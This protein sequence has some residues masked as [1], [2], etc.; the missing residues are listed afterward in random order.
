MDE[1]IRVNRAS[2]HRLLPAR[3]QPGAEANI[4]YIPPPVTAAP[5]YGCGMKPALRRF[6]RLLPIALLP[7]AA[8]ACST[9]SDYPSLAVRDVER[10][11]GTAK[12]AADD[13]SA[14]LPVLPPASAGLVSRLQGLV[15]VA[16]AADRQFQAE[17]PS[18]ERAAAAAGSLGSDSWSSASVALARLEASRSQAMIALAD[19]DTLYADAR[20]AAP[21]EPSPSAQAIGD[22]RAQV[23]GWVEAQ[24]AVIERLSARVK[25]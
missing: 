21:L 14:P 20:D 17:R 23:S 3:H 13:A 1:A 19:L 15:A 25:G 4:P 8:G 22:A 6:A 9:A 24:D 18:A 10:V 11:S 2:W 5:C 7:F 12:P 16:Q